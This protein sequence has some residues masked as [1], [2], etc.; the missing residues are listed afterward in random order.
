M[1]Q[2]VYDVVGGFKYVAGPFQTVTK[3]T[4]EAVYRHSLLKL[5]GG[6]VSLW[7]SGAKVFGVAQHAA[8]LG[9]D[10]IVSIDPESLYE[11][12]SYSKVGITDIGK[13]CPLTLE[14]VGI[15]VGDLSTM[16]IVSSTTSTTPALANPV[17]MVGLANNVTNVASASNHK[18]IVKFITGELE[19]YVDAV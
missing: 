16:R 4:N 19:P 1:A 12:T 11:A 6:K 18:C 5:S 10:V 15:R 13:F 3:K 8:A 14:N 7:T 2:P 9:E 17:Q